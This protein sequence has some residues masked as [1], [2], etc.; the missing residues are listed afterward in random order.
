MEQW[1]HSSW[2]VASEPAIAVFALLLLLLL[3][4]M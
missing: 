3:L 1:L 2:L 4:P